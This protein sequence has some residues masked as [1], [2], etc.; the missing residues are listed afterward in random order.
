MAE[1]QRFLTKKTHLIQKIPFEFK[2]ILHNELK[3]CK[4]LLAYNI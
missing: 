2:K 3:K 4:L 1:F